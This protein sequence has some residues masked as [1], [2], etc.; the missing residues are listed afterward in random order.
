MSWLEG[1]KTYIGIAITTLGIVLGWL[2]VGGEA[3]AQ[4]I[5]DN[6]MQVGDKILILWGLL[7]SIY[8]RWAAKPKAT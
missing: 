7:Q 8:G 6:I 5:V 1:K 2:G 3:E 4:T